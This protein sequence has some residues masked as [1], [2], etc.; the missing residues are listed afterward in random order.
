MIVR[1]SGSLSRRKRFTCAAS[2][3]VLGRDSYCVLLTI[4]ACVVVTLFTL[5]EK[6]FR[7]SIPLTFVFACIPQ[8][9]PAGARMFKYPNFSEDAAVGRKSFFNVSARPSV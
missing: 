9:R 3:D 8:G 2:D 6:S 1:E 4:I 5:L 7:L